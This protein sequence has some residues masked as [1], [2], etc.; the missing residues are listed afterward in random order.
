ML[1]VPVLELFSL[2]FWP[3]QVHHEPHRRVIRLG[4]LSLP[5]ALSG[6]HLASCSQ[7][8]LLQHLSFGKKK[9]NPVYS[10]PSFQAT[11]LRPSSLT[12][13]EVLYSLNQDSPVTFA[14]SF[15]S[16]KQVGLGLNHLCNYILFAFLMYNLHDNCLC[17]CQFGSDLIHIY[18]G[19][20][21]L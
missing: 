16:T 19:V 9:K 3:A 7:C 6:P 10:L 18:L 20:G 1:L 21:K 8:S 12:C 17:L 5:C 2:A 4:I 13:L 15:K 11:R 14:L